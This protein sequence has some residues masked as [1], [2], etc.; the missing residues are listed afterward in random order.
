M[1]AEENPRSEEE[2]DD[3]NDTSEYTD[4]AAIARIKKIN[5]RIQKL[6]ISAGKNEKYHYKAQNLLQ[7]LIMVLSEYDT[8][9]LTDYLDVLKKNNMSTISRVTGD[10]I[11]TIEMIISKEKE[12][13]RT[14]Q[15]PV[16]VVL[17]SWLCASML[18]DAPRVP[19]ARP[20]LH[21]LLP[22]L[23]ENEAQ[24][25]ADAW[26]RLTQLAAD[27]RGRL[28][29]LELRDAVAGPLGARLLW[30]A[31][32]TAA[33]DDMLRL[34]VLGRA[35]HAG[36]AAVVADE[37]GDL[38]LA[39]LTVSHTVAEMPTIDIQKNNLIH[40]LKIFFA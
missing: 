7:E 29:L 18:W 24:R 38:E 9:F 22:L 34:R 33:G 28:A 37:L 21:A 25:V 8:K 4:E 36:E 26:E 35:L 12:E 39:T 13:G 3:E 16:M 5:T 6:D 30:A 1:D 32:R 31:A 19:S 23:T 11:S 15:E 14:L 2:C 40:K 10:I 27:A 17:V 20:A